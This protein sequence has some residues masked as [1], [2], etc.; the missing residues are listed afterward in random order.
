MIFG[1]FSDLVNFAI[2]K[3]TRLFYAP[4][5]ARMEEVVCRF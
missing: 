4:S 3:N 5:F 2:K 1:V